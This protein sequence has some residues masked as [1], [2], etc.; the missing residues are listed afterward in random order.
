MS[1][2]YKKD[3]PAAFMTL[4]RIEKQ[5]GNYV[6]ALAYFD[7]ADK[8]LN[9][10]KSITM[11]NFMRGDALARLG[12]NAEAEAAFKEEIRLFPDNVQTYKNLVLLY[13]SEDRMAEAAQVIRDC[14]EKSPLPPSYLAVAQTLRVVGD[15]P[16]ARY[17]TAQGLRKFPRDPSLL[18]FA[19]TM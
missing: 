12:R 11:L 16:G 13:L 6:G 10:K 18:K 8:A 19:A 7:Q 2:V 1:L 4:G 5:R 15:E 14:V 3:K 9:D 17:W